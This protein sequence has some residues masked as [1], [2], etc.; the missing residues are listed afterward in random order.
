MKYCTECGTQ[1]P[2]KAKFCSNCGTRVPLPDSSAGVAPEAPTAP[3][4]PKLPAGLRSKFEIARKELRG[5]RREVAVLFA[6]IKGFTSMSETMDPEEVTLLLNPLLMSLGDAI[7]D[8]EGYVDKFMGDAVMGLFGAPLAHENDPER[9]V[10]A[11]LAMLE[12]IKRHNEESDQSLLLRVGINLGTVVA[13]QLGSEMQLQ[14]TVL[15]DAVNVASRLETAAEPNTVLV[16]EMVRQ[17]ISDRFVAEEVPPLTLKGVSE[18]VRAFRITGYEESAAEL[19]LE[20]TPFVGRNEEISTIQAFLERAWAS[21]AGALMI[22]AEAG[23]GKSRLVEEALA[24]TEADHLTL[25]IGFTPIRLPGQRPPA[26]ELFCQ[27]CAETDGQSGKD[28]ALELL[29]AGVEAHRAGVESLAREASPKAAPEA[30]AEDPQ[31]ARQNRWLAIAALLEAAARKRHVTLLIDNVHWADE[32]TQEFL[33]FLLPTLVHRPVAALVTSRPLDSRPWLPEKVEWLKVSPLDVETAEELLGDLLDDLAPEDRRDLIERSGGNPLF[34]EELIRTLGEAAGRSDAPT[35][36]PGT[37]QGLIMS[38]IDRL[39][40]PLQMLLQTAAVL[41]NRFSRSLL[42]LL[43]ALEQQPLSFENALASLERQGFLEAD[44][45]DQFRFR[46]A[47]TQ[48]V[49]YS[50]LLVRVRRVLHESAAQIGE[51]HFVDRIEAEAEFFSLHYWRAGQPEKAAPHLWVAGRAAADSYDMPRAE[52]YLKRAATAIDSNPEVISDVGERAAFNETF[53]TVLIYRGDFEAA[54]TW[55]R[56]LEELGTAEEQPTWVAR[57]LE[58]R[59]RVAWYRGRLDEAIEFFERGLVI[60]PETEP[61][62]AADLRNDMGLVFYYRSRADEAFEYHSAAL[63]LREQHGDQ[64]GIAKSLS[65]IGNLLMDLRNDLDGAESHYRR[66]FDT[67]EAIGDRRMMYSALNNLGRVAMERGAWR[68]ALT[69]LRQAERLLED[70]GWTFARYV[71][72]QNRISCEISLGKIDDALR[73]LDICLQQGDEILEP[74]NRINTRLCFFDAYLQALDHDRARSALDEAGRLIDELGVEEQRHEVQ[75]CTGRWLVAIGDWAKA[76]EVFAAAEKTAHASGL[77]AATVL[78]RAHRCRAEVRARGGRP[79]SCDA[80][81]AGNRS[82]EALV[83]FLRTDAEIELEPTAESA[84]TLGDVIDK[85][86]E[87]GEIA[88][89]RAAAER[90]AD[91]HRVMGDRRRE[92]IALARA[93]RAMR[94]LGRNL[95]AEFKS[96][97]LAHPRNAALL[98]AAGV[99]VRKARA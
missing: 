57:G 2:A 23:I 73:H 42:G 59:G 91:V 78:A 47:L 13:A 5:D 48:E 63:R 67:A 56:R 77:V 37:L 24:R 80:D 19:R 45:D 92:R 39:S 89:E 40:P 43:Y 54:E 44:G 74:V 79:E 25:E 85:A 50:G 18:P 10:L 11:G 1:L 26:T 6:D 21:K 41:G 68:E 69:T 97:F 28:K 65:N 51:E 3:P 35:T 76:A 16:S 58:R 93:L 7:Y 9:A 94:S 38:R 33:T 49:A 82:L 32:A 66:A 64:V 34:L 55:F 53:G 12:I 70:I 86:A 20:R 95:P 8:Y 29:G 22:E 75:L 17:R 81:L 4:G 62:V 84:A 60:V 96:A 52:K 90:L 98:E 14:Y 46:H 27:L 71:T 31:S 36:V 87:L 15:G 61:L 88:L 72:L 30:E 83:K 99:P